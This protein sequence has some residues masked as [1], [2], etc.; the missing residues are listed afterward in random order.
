VYN[1][2]GFISKQTYFS[3]FSSDSI[4]PKAYG[5]PKIHKK[6]FPYR[7][8]VS[9]INTA[10]YPIASYIQK[11]ISIS[12]TYDEKHVKNSFDLYKIL[13]GKKIGNTDILLSLD[14][15]SLF[16][17][18]PQDLAIE[19]ISNRWNMIKKNTNIP[20][21]D[22]IS[23]LQLI[24]SSTYFTFN[25]KIYKQTYG[26]PMGSPLSPVIADIVLQ[27]LEEKALKKIN[28]KI[29][30]YHRYV[31]DIILSAPADRTS[32]IL[33]TFNSFHNR[34]QF[35]MEFENDREL[36]F[37]DLTI[38]VVNN[39]IH[40]DWFH[41]NTFSGR[42]LSYLSNHPYCHKI[43]TIYNLVDRAILLSH[44]S[45]QQKNLELC[46]RL[47]LENGY[48]ITLIFKTINMR[49]KNL[50]N[51]KLSLNTNATTVPKKNGCNTQ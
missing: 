37:L 3:L 11:I 26:T 15:I 20:M 46:I 4:L 10:L 51:N 33:D 18:I 12:L 17:N 8:I 39:K 1:K 29:P 35:T 19:G 45:Y 32:M 41:K 5:L 48:P 6:S 47:L 38:K 14:V 2:K 31:D 40:L 28:A 27:D 25:G 22:F 9:S 24:L 50:F 49:L 36:S 30:F 7:I 21:K 23:A 16:N 13:S 34:L 42:V 44:P 43:G